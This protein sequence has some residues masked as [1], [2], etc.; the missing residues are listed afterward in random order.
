MNYVSLGGLCDTKTALNFDKRTDEATLPFD[1]VRSTIEGIIDCVETD[2]ANFFPSKIEREAR[3]TD[4]NAYLG[5]YIGFF[6]DNLL[7][8]EVIESYKRRFERFR[9]KLAN[10]KR[11]VF[12][13]TIV[14]QD[15]EEETK[16]A[17]KLCSVIQ[18]KYPQLDFII[19]FVIT[20]QAKTGYFT[21][22]N[23][24]SFLFTLH[25]AAY[26]ANCGTHYRP[27]FDFIESNDLFSCTLQTDETIVIDKT[28]PVKTWFIN[29]IPMVNE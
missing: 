15:Y 9:E 6:H 25:Y 16:H 21:Q 12:V 18:E 14:R 7:D 4:W 27:I 24:K 28:T 20:N 11:I 29:G 8:Q 23:A 2:F 19:V 13:R 1:W 10:S 22:V 17:E 5:R 3:I 26:H